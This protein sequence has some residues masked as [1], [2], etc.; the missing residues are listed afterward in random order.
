[1]H[2]ALAFFRIRR[3]FIMKNK[4]AQPESSLKEN[5]EVAGFE[6]CPDEKAFTSAPANRFAVRLA[7]LRVMSELCEQGRLSCDV[8]SGEG[9]QRRGEV[10]AA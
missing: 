7:R 3:Y 2:K 9:W 4:P 1:M 5:L 10:K 6:T 8:R